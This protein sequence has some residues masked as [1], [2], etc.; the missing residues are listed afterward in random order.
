[1]KVI[2][3]NG[4]PRK[5]WNTAT[6][7]RYALDGVTSKGGDTKLVHLYDLGYKGCYSC[8]ACKLKDG[9]S[10]GR[11]AINDDLKPILEEIA[12]ADALILGAP[13]YFGSITG[14]MRSFL[15]R[16]AFPYLKY[17]P[18]HS[19]LFKRKL[20]TA[21]ISPMNIPETMLPEFGYDAT[22]KALESLLKRIF[23]HCEFLPVTDTLQF[24]DYSK[25]DVSLFDP[26]AKKC[27][28][29]EVFPT[30]CKKA[31]DLGARFAGGGVE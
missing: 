21:W 3:I 6:L 18:E 10:Y 22:F 19:S 31:F 20:L 27:R 17:D 7:L 16:L 14:Q 30:D 23:G 13:I 24:D 26:A 5:E 9:K 28:R 11:C 25:Y 15:E 1:M 8:F 2:A 29:E 4:G 12:E